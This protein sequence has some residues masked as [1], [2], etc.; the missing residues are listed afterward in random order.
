MPLFNMTGL[1]LF[2]K[3]EKRIHRGR[4]TPTVY[5][6]L[7]QPGQEVEPKVAWQAGCDGCMLLIPLLRRQRQG[8]RSSM[9]SSGTQQRLLRLE[10]TENEEKKKEEGENLRFF[11]FHVWIHSPA[12]GSK[13]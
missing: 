2:E 5:S 11:P 10:E 6:V 7:F 9:S 8:I 4:H 1:S 3:L 12:R 13:G